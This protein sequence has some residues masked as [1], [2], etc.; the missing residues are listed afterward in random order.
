VL[1]ALGVR[2]LAVAGARTDGAFRYL[3]PAS[4]VPTMREHLDRAAAGTG[5]S[6][7]RLVV[8]QGIL[9]ETD[10]VVA[11][12]VA[13]VWI[14]VYLGLPAYVT[15]LRRLGFDDA[16]LGE[17]PSDR[18]VDALVAWGDPATVR[19]RLRAVAAAGVDQVAVV[20]LRPDGTVGDAAGFEAVAPPW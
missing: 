8:A 20:P 14:K 16:D 2:M 18:L 3:V 5:R 4:A 10:P 13:R 11:R 15:N 7:A 9:I 6:D 17:T 19:E 1:A 12:R